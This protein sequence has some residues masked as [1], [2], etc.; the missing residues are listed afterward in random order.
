MSMYSH[1]RGVIPRERTWACQPSDS[2]VHLALL[3]PNPITPNPVTPNPVAPNPVTPNPN[4]LEQHLRLPA[5]PLGLLLL[6]RTL[7][8]L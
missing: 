6:V 4:P 1:S 8:H 3:T 5:V 7:E 2:L